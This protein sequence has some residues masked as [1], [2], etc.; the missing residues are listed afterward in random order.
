MSL[1]RFCVAARGT[2]NHTHFSKP[3][4]PAARGGMCEA[5]RVDLGAASVGKITWAQ[6]FAKWGP[7]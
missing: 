6:Y 5:Q 1:A 2:A 4:R 3:R 7:A